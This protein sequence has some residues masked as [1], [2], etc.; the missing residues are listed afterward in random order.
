MNESSRGQDKKLV[1]NNKLKKKIKLIPEIHNEF[2]Y[3]KKSLYDEN[4]NVIGIS[5][6][7]S[8]YCEGA[9]NR[10]YSKETAEKIF[11]T[12]AAFAK[13]SFNKSH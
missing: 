12:M 4:H 6:E 5:E 13:Y 2:V 8:D 11:D 3:G 9:I 7:N 10:G 1:V